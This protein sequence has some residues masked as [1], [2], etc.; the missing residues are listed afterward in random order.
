MTYRITIPGLA[1]E[2]RR[3]CDAAHL[4]ARRIAHDAIA[5]QGGL[6]TAWGHK[7]MRAVESHD[8][9]QGGTFVIRDYVMYYTVSKGVAA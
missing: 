6:D 9:G 3:R 1:A 2:T 7:A 4:A 8:P 5:C